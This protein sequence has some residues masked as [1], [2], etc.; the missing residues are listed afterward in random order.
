MKSVF[1]S[2]SRAAS[3]ASPGWPCPP[4]KESDRERLAINQDKTPDTYTSDRQSGDAITAAA[5]EALTKWLA[6]A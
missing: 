3:V 6:L 4:N 2:V 5:G 1:F